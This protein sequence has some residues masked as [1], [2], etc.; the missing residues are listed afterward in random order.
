[1][2]A[3]NCRLRSLLKILGEP[4]F[5]REGATLQHI[6]TLVLLPKLL[7]QHQWLQRSLIAKM[8]LMLPVTRFLHGETGRCDFYN[9]IS[10]VLGTFK[11]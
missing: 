8:V 7:G 1:M 6:L 4:E 11:V 5:V 10:K 3:H 9:I 2:Q